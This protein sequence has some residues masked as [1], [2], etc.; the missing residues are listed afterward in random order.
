MSEEDVELMRHVVEDFN[1]GGVE[2]V[3]PYFDTDI[4]W[5]GPP[6][7]V[8][9]HLYKGH[10]GL[11]KLA[12]QWTG[13]FDEYRLDPERFIDAGTTVVALLFARGRIKGS[14]IPVEQEVSWVCRVENGRATQ[15]QV[16]FS[17]AEALEATGLSRWRNR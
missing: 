2:A 16:Y 11:R 14:A 10:E 15:V 12:S 9:D 6:E 7:W 17:W 8:D 13:S 5:V 4:D 3:L 1:R